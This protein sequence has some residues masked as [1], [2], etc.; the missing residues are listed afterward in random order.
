[1]VLPEPEFPDE[2]SVSHADLEG[3]AIHGVD[4]AFGRFVGEPLL[5]QGKLSR[6]ELRAKVSEVLPTVGLPAGSIDLYPHEFSGGGRQRFLSPE[7]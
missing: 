7:R 6:A 3:Y 5:A 2:A 1:L 4:D